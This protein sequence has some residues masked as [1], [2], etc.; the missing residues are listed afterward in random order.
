MEEVHFSRERLIARSKEIKDEL[1]VMSFNST[2]PDG[3]SRHIAKVAKLGSMIR[4]ATIDDMDDDVVA[5]YSK[6]RDEELERLE[7]SPNEEFNY[8]AGLFRELIA[9]EQTL[10]PKSYRLAA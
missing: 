4:A 5:V 6:M 2:G 7:A 8:V 3:V 9:I 10:E 1:S